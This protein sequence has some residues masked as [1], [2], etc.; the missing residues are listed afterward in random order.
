MSPAP[1]G[2]AT[3]VAAG[4]AGLWIPRSALV[5][6]G[7]LAGVFVAAGGKAEL[8]WVSTGD[9]AADQVWVRAGLRAGEVVIDAPGALRDGAAVEV[10]P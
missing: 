9:A 7:D 8:R 3:A 2:G 10:Q 1:T 6:R 5:E 4:P